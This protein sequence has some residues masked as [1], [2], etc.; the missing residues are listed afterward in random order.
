[1]RRDQNGESRSV[2][3]DRLPPHSVEAE[4]GVLGCI[5]LAPNECMGTCIEKLHAV[6]EEFY[7]LRH[8]HLYQA[9]SAMYDRRDPIDLL[10]VQQML[11]DK[12]Q[13]EAIGGLAYLAQLPDCVPSAANLDHY[14]GI[15]CDKFLMRS[16]ILV[17]TGIVQD[18]FEN[19]HEPIAVLDRAEAAVLKVG[20]Q[21]N[22]HATVKEMKGL[23]HG[24]INRVEEFHQRAGALSGI[25]T[26]FV[27]MDKMTGGLNNEEMIVLAA[28]PSV[29]KSS[30]AMNIADHVSLNLGLPVGV[31]SLEMSAESLALRMLCS[32]ARVNLSNIRDGFL[33][34]RDY[35]KLTHAAGQLIKAPIFIDDTSSLTITQLRSRGRRMWQQYGIKLFIIDYLQIM[36]GAS[37]RRES[38]IANI[39]GGVK[40]LARELKVPIIILSQLN[41]ELDKEKGRKPRLSDLRESGA[42]E[43][44]ADTVIMLY[45]V[46]T[47]H[48][49]EGGY[50]SDVEPVNALIAKQRNGPTGDVHL[51]FMKCYTRFESAAKVT[52]EDQP[53]ML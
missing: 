13:L 51:T 25:S 37:N 27:N 30:L 28:R 29:G 12:Q 32:R 1:M 19:E 31:F 20:H 16:A 9:L 33:A 43:Q 53:T 35:P 6:G 34:D 38:E 46:I 24:A 48:E 8:R 52:T 4:Q 11:R 22:G 17:G 45:K 14:L 49:D 3:V 15:L 41:R 5:L 44:D 26:G 21:R 42:I 36:G 47:D 7:D 10:S 2:T 39:S 50:S 18:V 40:S 23:I